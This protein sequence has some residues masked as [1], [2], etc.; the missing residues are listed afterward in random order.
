MKKIFFINPCNFCFNIF[1]IWAQK[2]KNFFDKKLSN[3]TLTV[4]LICFILFWVVF[5]INNLDNISFSS[6][7][8]T[9]ILETKNV[10]KVHLKENENFIKIDWKIYKLILVKDMNKK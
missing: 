10:K 5:T 3:S 1:F 4:A 8:K 6:S 2:Y 7:L 9:N